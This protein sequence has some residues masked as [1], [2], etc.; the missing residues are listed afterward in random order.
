MQKFREYLLDHIDLPEEKVVIASP[1][2]AYRI[3][4]NG[5][6]DK[7]PTNFETIF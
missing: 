3:E 5:I 1:D 6:V 2:M 4:S 7:F